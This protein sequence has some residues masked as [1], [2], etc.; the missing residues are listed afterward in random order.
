MVDCYHLLGREEDARRLFQ[1]LLDVRSKLGLVSEEYAT[2]ERRLVGNFPQAF[3]H[4]GLINTAH[5]LS[6]PTGP[7]RH[8]GVR[9]AP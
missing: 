8:R 5:N 9:R 3:T 1:R 6:T 2:K 7:A 4:V